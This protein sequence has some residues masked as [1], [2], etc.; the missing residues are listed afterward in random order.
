MKA[1]DATI[2]IMIMAWCLTK[3][4]FFTAGMRLT[5][6]T[7]LKTKT[8]QINI[9]PSSFSIVPTNREQM[10]YYWQR[11]P[12]LPTLVAISPENINKIYNQKKMAIESTARF[13][14]I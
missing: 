14:L 10:F 1:A 4:I 7:T 5:S 8:T 12:F 13:L 3:D 6:Q 2:E 11:Y 9:C